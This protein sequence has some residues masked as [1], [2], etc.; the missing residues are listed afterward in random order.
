MTTVVVTMFGAGKPSQ[1]DEALCLEGRDGIVGSF[2]GLEDPGME[3][4]ELLRQRQG[5]SL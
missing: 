3:V 4:D 5:V 1:P 2:L